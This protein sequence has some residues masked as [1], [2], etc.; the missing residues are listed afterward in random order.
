[1]KDRAAKAIQ[2][3][4]R[5]MAVAEDAAASLREQLTEALDDLASGRLIFGKHHIGA[6]VFASSQE[7]LQKGLSAVRSEML[8][9]G[10]TVVREDMNMEPA[11]WAMFPGNFAYAGGRAAMIS[12]S[13][14]AGM[15][16]FTASPQGE[17]FSVWGEAIS[18][19]QTTAA[20]NP[21]LEPIHHYWSPP[22][23]Q[24]SLQAPPILQIDSQ[25]LNVQL[26]DFLL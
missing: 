26:G 16:S 24:G 9:K 12:S 14:F 25:E 1:M 18:V 8:N 23:S 7:K 17:K 13:N 6:T 21:Q 22:A 15:V 4:Q 10:L 20:T 5:R 19:F 3:Q 2:L 11:F